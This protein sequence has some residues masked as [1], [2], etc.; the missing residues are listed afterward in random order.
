MKAIL[1]DVV[2][3]IVREVELDPADMLGSIYGALNCQM[4]TQATRL[5]GRD[6]VWVDDEGLLHSKVQHFFDIGAHMPL[7]GN[8]LVVGINSI[9]DTVDC[10]STVDEIRAR[11]RFLG[12]LDLEAEP[13]RIGM[14]EPEPGHFIIGADV[15]EQIRERVAARA[16]VR[17]GE[18]K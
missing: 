7:A 8:G 14:E 10:K 12:A 5:N 9:G 16:R 3:Q 17:D 2:A 6:I 15:G 4:F 1:I 18:V 11:V 13:L